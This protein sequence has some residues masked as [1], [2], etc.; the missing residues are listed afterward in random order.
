MK[1]ILDSDTKNNREKCK[2]CV[3]DKGKGTNNY[4]EDEGFVI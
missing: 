3:F 1:L 4:C 2:G